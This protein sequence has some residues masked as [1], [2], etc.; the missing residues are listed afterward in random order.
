MSPIYKT[1]YLSI[2]AIFS[3]FFHE[4]RE[5]LLDWSSF[6]FSLMA[7]NKSGPRAQIQECCRNVKIAN[8]VL[9]NSILTVFACKWARTTL[10]I[11][12]IMHRIPRKTL[13]KSPPRYSAKE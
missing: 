2:G 9:Q 3:R 11:L 7:K 6:P 8:L 10:T 12:K 5:E 4:T 1:S 13:V